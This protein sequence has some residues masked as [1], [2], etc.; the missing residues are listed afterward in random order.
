MSSIRERYRGPARS[1][2]SPLGRSLILLPFC[3]I[4][5]AGPGGARAQGAGGPLWV[6][7]DGQP[8]GTSARVVLNTDLSDPATTSLDVFISGF[9]VA[10]RTGDDGRVYQDVRVP[11]LPNRTIPGQPA[12]PEVRVDLGIV[13]G[14]SGASLAQALALDSRAFSGY[15]IWPSPI[16]AEL[17][18]GAPSQF[19]RD[20][21]IY[22]STADFPPG[23]GYGTPTR[24]TLGGLPASRCAAFPL[25]WNPTA[26]T[27]T[28]AA[29]S[30]FTFDHGG[31]M[32]T[33]MDL[34][35]E[36]ANSAAVALLNWTAIQPGVSINWNQFQGDF[37]FVCPVDWMADL[38]PLVKQKKALGYAVTVVNFLSSG[39]S[40]AQLK[41]A[42]QSWYAG[43]RPGDDHYCLLV[44]AS[45]SAPY[46]LDPNG[47][48][49]DKTLSSVDGDGEPEIFL[50]RLYVTSAAEL[51]SQVKKILDYETG[52][53]V[54]NDGNVLLVAHHQQDQDFD[55]V[56]YHEAVRTASYAQVTPVF[57]TCYGTNPFLG[58]NDITGAIVSGVGVVAY[59]GH[60]EPDGWLHWNYFDQSF[61]NADAMALANGSLTPVVW[62]FACQTGD[63]RSGSSLANGF[64]KNTQGG[65]VSFYGA[66]D[67]T[68]GS[69]VH[70][71]EDSLFQAVYGRGVTRHGQAVALAEHAVVVADSL[72]GFDAAYKYMLYGDP[73]MTVKRKNF[74]GPWAPIDLVT[75]IDVIAPCPGAGCCPSCPG[76]Q[77]DIQV[78]DATGAPVPGVKVALWKPRFA[79][80]DEILD[81]RYSAEDG[82]VHIPAAQLT[83]GTL[84]VGFDDGDGRAGIDSIEVMPSVSAVAA[85][86]GAHAYRFAVSPSVTAGPARFVF[87]TALDRPA[88]IA[89]Y[90]VDGRLVRRIRAPIGAASLDWDGRGRAGERLGQGVYI[91]R[92][93]GEDVR[94]TTRI[95]MLR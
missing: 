91:A 38:A 34:T 44:G 67:Q 48:L 10:T 43:T 4:T 2:S 85:G 40:C 26:G 72:F 82:W 14:A 39:V 74:G 62:S 92:V 86:H 8:E 12:L 23:D 5:L 93:E 9:Y 24:A 41:Q 1:A 49:S 45:G 17:H 51:Q 65:A 47:Q 66:V 80:G 90:S 95:V 42:I 6:S 16:P 81:N 83:A 68:Y 54:N 3:F 88:T 11:G 21:A 15:T 31:A 89:I 70:V 32:S 77:I 79:E 29:H 27:L 30:R 7:L 22:S 69:V 18:D 61:A 52:P 94:A 73:A 50:G 46:C 20:E 25:H 58:N 13:T 60:G 55:F 56:S 84:Y 57:S 28:V 59:M 71:L 78:R 33:P 64:M 35:I 76:P 75:P 87:G 19:S 53:Q 36:R 63:P 37:L